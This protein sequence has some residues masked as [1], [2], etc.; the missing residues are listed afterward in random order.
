[1]AKKKTV[2]KTV[3]PVMEPEVEKEP[4]LPRKHI[5]QIKKRILLPA[6]NT[7]VEQQVGEIIYWESTDDVTHSWE[8]GHQIYMDNLVNRALKID[9]KTWIP[10]EHTRKWI[11]NLSNALLDEG[12]GASE[13]LSLYETE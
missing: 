7:H 2:E 10:R 6:Y 8:A 3:V 5:V 13:V 9:D 12:Y 1:M 4:E 11:E